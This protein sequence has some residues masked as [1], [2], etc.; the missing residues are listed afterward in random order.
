MEGMVES[1]VDRWRKKEVKALAMCYLYVQY[2]HEQTG[3]NLSAW[4][5]T[6]CTHTICLAYHTT[7]IEAEEGACEVWQTRLRRA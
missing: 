3:R 1:M 6:V 5:F 2:I 7:F 4:N